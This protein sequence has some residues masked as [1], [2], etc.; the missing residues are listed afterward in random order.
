MGAVV[1][2]ALDGRS[3]CVVVV[4]FLSITWKFSE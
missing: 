3:A 2:I 1:V 4:V